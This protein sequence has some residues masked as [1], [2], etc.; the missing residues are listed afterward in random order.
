MSQDTAVGRYLANLRERAGFKQ[1]DLAK[2]LEW[3]GAQLSRIESGERALSSEELEMILDRI[4]TPE[5][6]KAKE[7]LAREWQMLPAPA[8][9]DPDADLLWEAEQTARKINALAESPDVKQFF[10]RRLVRFREE[11]A[12]SAARVLEKRYS[13][14]FVGTIGAGKSTAICRVEGLEIPSTKGMPKSVLQTGGGGITICEVHLRRGPGYGLIIEPASEDE[15]R[16]SVLEFARFLKN[17]QQAAAE[18]EDGSEGGAPGVSREVERAIRGMSDLKRKP[19]EKGP[20]GAIIPGIDPARE[21]AKAFDDDKSLS[22]EILARMQLHKRDR[23]DTWLP[24]E[25]ENT[26]RE[27]LQEQFLLVNNGG[28]PEF[29]LPRRIELVLPSSILG[30]DDLEITLIDTQ[31]IDD[32][33][34]RRDIEQHFDDPHAVVMLCSIFAEA[35]AIPVRR[36]LTRAKEAGVRGLSTRAAIV[37][38]P[39]AGEALS[40]PD[41]EGATPDDPL[42]GYELKRGQMQLTLHPLGLNE[43][44]IQFFNAAEDDPASL[45]TFVLER[46]HAVREHH[47]AMLREIIEGAEALL[48]NYEREQ[49]REAMRTV[50]TMLDVWLNTHGELPRPEQRVH[51]SLV[52]ATKTAHPRTIHAAIVRE[53]EWPKLDYAHQLSH[54]ARRVAAGLLQDKMADFRGVATN[55]LN[56]PQWVDAHDLVRQSMRALEQGFDSVLR[57]SQLVGQTVHAAELRGDIDFW[58]DCEEQW[59]QGGGYRDR[60]NERNRRW[61]EKTTAHRADARV[62]SAVSNGWRDAVG[63]VRALLAME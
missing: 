10:E 9:G 8:L 33:A 17:A 61:F 26:P 50:A 13:A 46:I 53:G 12:S 45:K 63:S 38:L 39:R 15:I 48:A 22:V 3:S 56:N 62:Y 57:K 59:G 43:V 16:R 31:G 27:W 18:P 60:V 4:D 25:K 7:E 35:P 44:P 28:H 2:R 21:L 34:E 37:V 42:I 55:L 54:G 14:A 36:L 49:A 58:R 51:D 30:R 6:A 32:I 5:A 40:M 41:D 19:A 1:A 24:P 20:D 47:R 52:A 23:R 29:S 11:L